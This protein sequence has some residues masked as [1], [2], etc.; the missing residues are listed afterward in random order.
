MDLKNGLG[1]A[2]EFGKWQVFRANWL[3]FRTE[4]AIELAGVFA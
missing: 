3:F 4:M 2:N 1:K